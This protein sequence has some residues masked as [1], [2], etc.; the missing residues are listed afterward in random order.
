VTE[1]AAVTVTEIATEIVGV[2]VI[3]SGSGSEMATAG[4]AGTGIESGTGGEEGGRCRRLLLCLPSL[5]GLSWGACT[6]ARCACVC[7]FKS[8]SSS[9]MLVIL[10]DCIV[11]ATHS[12]CVQP[13]QPVHTYAHVHIAFPM[14]PIIP[15]RS[16]LAVPHQVSSV[17][18]FGCFVEL[19]CFQKRVSVCLCVCVSSLCVGAHC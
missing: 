8:E 13:S 10:H 18:E 5:K 19:D 12:L 7:V 14:A 16:F 6:R 4:V 17:M 1:I 3:A 15:R 2:I 11:C 9:S